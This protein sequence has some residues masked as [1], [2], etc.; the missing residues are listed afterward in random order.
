MVGLRISA[1][2]RLAYLKAL[3]S[4]PVS[5]LDTLPSGQTSNTITTTANVLQVGI[6]EKLGII[7]RKDSN[8]SSIGMIHDLRRF[9]G[10]ICSQSLTTLDFMFR[11]SE[12]IMRSM[13]T[14][15]SRILGYGN[16][17]DYSCVQV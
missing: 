6:S 5:V 12:T 3:F 2:L 1:K 14:R 16:H 9:F 8:L 13:L 4:L 7:L 17:G 15:S 11:A 10:E